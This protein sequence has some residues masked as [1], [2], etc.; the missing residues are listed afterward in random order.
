MLTGIDSHLD[1]PAVSLDASVAFRPDFTA[2]HSLE[3]CSTKLEPA[4]PRQSARV[5]REIIECRYTLVHR[6]GAT[7]T[8][9][10]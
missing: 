1:L 5:T 3:R 2:L 7:I 4:L 8:G 9:M 10:A 6:D